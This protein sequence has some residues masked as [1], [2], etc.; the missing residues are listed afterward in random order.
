MLPDGTKPAHEAVDPDVDLH[1]R[2]QRHEF[3]DGPVRLLIVIAVG[4]VIGATTRHGLDLAF[5][6]EADD[7]AWA[8]FGINVSGCA[9]IGAL[10]VLIEHVWTDHRLLRPFLGVG[11]L[12]G[13]TTLST[14][15]L[16][17]NQAVDVGAPR[18]ALIYLAATPMAALAAVWIAATL[19]R[20]VTIR[21]TGRRGQ[22]DREHAME[23]A[24]S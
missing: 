5:P 12:G 15:V 20:A 22:L 6:H 3:E 23:S 8:T 2:A 1:I 13:F 9:L 4:G 24:G 14:Y 16:D 19:T 17:I 11:V 10:M 21:R 18:I 7:F